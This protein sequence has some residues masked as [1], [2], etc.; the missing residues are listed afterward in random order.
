VPNQTPDFSPLGLRCLPILFLTPATP[1]RSIDRQRYYTMESLL[2]QSRAMCPYLKKTSPATLRSLSTATHQS[3]GGG[4]ITNLQFIARRC[5]V[6]NK[7]LAVQSARI[8]TATYTKAATR[9]GTA[10]SLLEKKLHT[11]AE[12]KASVDTTK[13][14]NNRQQGLCCSLLGH[15]RTVR[16]RST[17]TS[18]TSRPR[19]SIHP[20]AGHLHRTQTSRTVCG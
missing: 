13:V 3:P 16:L 10:K 2:S 15:I 1:Q 19:S 7:A 14:F 5:P 20:Q 4:T 9:A 18:A 12:K 8:R 6:M 17:F 11:S